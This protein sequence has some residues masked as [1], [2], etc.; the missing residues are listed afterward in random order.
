MSANRMFE[1]AICGALFALRPPAYIKYASGQQGSDRI[2]IS[3]ISNMRSSTHAEIEPLVRR[4]RHLED[5][6]QHWI[7]RPLR[8]QKRYSTLSFRSLNAFAS[9]P[10]L[11]LDS[12]KS[13]NLPDPH[14]GE[15]PARLTTG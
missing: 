2:H 10:N 15:T 14:G 11:R 6:Q 7:R 13:A 1:I 4:F 12:L 3:S 5:A 9:D 8:P